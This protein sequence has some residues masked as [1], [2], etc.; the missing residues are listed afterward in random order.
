MCRMCINNER[1]VL[2]HNLNY[3]FIYT[4]RLM[5][6]SVLIKQADF[7]IFNFQFLKAFRSFEIVNC[8]CEL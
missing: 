8:N 6:V 1:K 2:K 4:N 5:F 3:L 7:F